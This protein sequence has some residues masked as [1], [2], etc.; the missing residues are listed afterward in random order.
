MVS[1]FAIHLSGNTQVPLEKIIGAKG[2]GSVAQELSA[3]MIISDIVPDSDC[4]LVPSKDVRKLGAEN[5]KPGTEFSFPTSEMICD[6]MFTTGTTGKSKGVM[7][8]HR[9]VV[10]VSENVQYGAEIPENFNS[11]SAISSLVDRILDEE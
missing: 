11:V 8:S 7:E 4:V 10:A 2:L 6:I 5:F 3:K 1:A 9:A